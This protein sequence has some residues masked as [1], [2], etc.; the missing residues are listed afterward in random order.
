M[1]TKPVRISITSELI[2]QQARLFATTWSMVGG[3]FDSVGKNFLKRTER[4]EATLQRMVDQL[5]QERDDYRTAEE[6]QIVLRQKAAERE[7]A[8]AADLENLREKASLAVIS[9]Y[10]IVG[11][12][13]WNNN[14]RTAFEALSTL[15]SQA[16]ITSPARRDAEIQADILSECVVEL[17]SEVMKA[18]S[19]G[20]QYT[21]GMALD[22]LSRKCLALRQK[23]EGGETQ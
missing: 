2:M 20:Q 19:R 15:L 3:P 9:Y 17:T 5:A 4:V 13:C 14:D 11:N 12:S 21:V 22:V 8:L 18:N 23:T 6:H 16:P 1:G 7:Q 10:G